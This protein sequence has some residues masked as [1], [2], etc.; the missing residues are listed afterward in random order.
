MNTGT[1]AVAIKNFESRGNRENI[2]QEA[3][4]PSPCREGGKNP[5]LIRLRAIE[6]GGWR[7]LFSLILADFP[8]VGEARCALA[9]ADGGSRVCLTALYLRTYTPSFRL[10][11]LRSLLERIVPVPEK[12][13]VYFSIGLERSGSASLNRIYPLSGLMRRL[14]TEGAL[15]YRS[16]K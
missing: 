2:I 16:A 12:R 7:E 3:P 11:E 14:K 6:P 1:L 8:E 10:R 4:R 5:S 15:L 13:N 9:A